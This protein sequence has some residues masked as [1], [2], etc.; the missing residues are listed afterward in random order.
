MMFDV[1]MWSFLLGRDGFQQRRSKQSRVHCRCRAS[2][3]SLLVKTHRPERR[4]S[5]DWT[6]RVCALAMFQ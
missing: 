2:G 3:V 5:I 1:I 4:R 6:P